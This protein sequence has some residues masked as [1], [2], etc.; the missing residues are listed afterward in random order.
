MVSSAIFADLDNQVGAVG[1]PHGR[2]YMLRTM[3][4]QCNSWYHRL[5][6]MPLNQRYS[7]EDLIW[8]VRL[9]LKSSATCSTFYVPGNGSGYEVV[10]WSGFHWILDFDK[11]FVRIYDITIY[12]LYIRICIL[13]M[14]IYIYSHYL[15]RFKSTKKV[16]EQIWTNTRF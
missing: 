11:I 6:V 15:S 12:N 16:N 2:M 1:C 3:I 4:I 10:N 9:S 13:C 7:K 5:D 14:Y 8:E